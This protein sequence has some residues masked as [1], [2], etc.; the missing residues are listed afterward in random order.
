MKNNDDLVSVIMSTYNEDLKW[1]EESVESILNQTYKNIEFIIILD[2]PD[3]LPLKNMLEAYKTKDNRIILLLNEENKGLVKSLN[4]ALNYCSGKYIARMDADDISLPNRLESQKRYLEVNDLDFVFSGV[5]VI[6]ENSNESYSS[7][8][9]ELPHQKIKRLLE[10]TNSTYHPTWFVKSELYNELRGY[11]D[12]SYCEDYDFSLRSISK[13]YRIGKMN[14]NILKYRIRGN[15]IS[16]SFSLEQFLN[17][18]GTLKLYK[19]KEL[20]NEEK[21][22]EMLVLSKK[23]ACM[24]ESERY[25]LADI[26]MNEA[27]ALIKNKQTISGAKRFLKSICISKYYRLK[28]LDYLLYTIYK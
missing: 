13:G 12:V 27:V 28:Q 5:T 25:R 17:M 19:N 1:I 10:I 15:S 24:R 2:N 14:E 22:K 11:R 21:V 9:K 18:K 26:E 8:I 20:D 23:K 3:N 7:N 16:R 4:I 6:D